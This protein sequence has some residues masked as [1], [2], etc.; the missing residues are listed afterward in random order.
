M[1]AKMFKYQDVP[2]SV[3]DIAREVLSDLAI[4]KGQLAA[5]LMVTERSLYDWTQK[6]VNTIPPKGRRLIRLHQAI[7]ELNAQMPKF[8]LRKDSVLKVLRD[9]RIPISESDED[10]GD[11][12]ALIS[13]IVEFPDDHGWV[14]N[15]Q[16]AIHDY[17]GFAAMQKKRG[18]R[19]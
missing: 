14:A 5:L 7:Q 2:E 15:V 6:N 3:M 17:V 16:A 8:S 4:S 10:G 11:S 1:E 18:V 19:V 12:M 13:Y 9:G